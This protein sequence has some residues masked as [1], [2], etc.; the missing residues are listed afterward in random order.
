[1]T[2]IIPVKK[3]TREELARAHQEIGPARLVKM[4]TER[5]LSSC[6]TLI[7]STFAAMPELSRQQMDSRLPRLK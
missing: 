5:P 7:R 6:S 4:L 2:F 1:M 3:R